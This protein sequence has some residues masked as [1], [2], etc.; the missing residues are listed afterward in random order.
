MPDEK[1]SPAVKPAEST[2]A[3]NGSAAPTAAGAT[4][5][6]VTATTGSV[7]AASA[8]DHEAITRLADDLLPA[9]IAKLGASNLGEIEVRQGGWKARLRKPAVSDEARR[10]ARAAAAAS[11]AP[12]GTS[13]TAGGRSADEARRARE[14]AAAADESAHA[15][16]ISPA[17]G[18]FHPQR[19]L[20]VGMRVRSGD[21]IGTVDVLGVKQ[22]V[23]S[24]VDGIIGSSLV[25]VGEAVE[26][27]QEL[28]RI[29]LP[30]RAATD[31]ADASAA[32]SRGK[33]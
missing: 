33:A 12:R 32:S 9:L 10:A 13:V 17:V 15:T 25:E 1:S 4:S 24:P 2:G 8:R 26:Y 6:A 19:D 11:A 18:I 14:Q 7:S 16:A 27:G 31:G 21:R 3:A 23:T 22:D 28:V 5:T 29:E 30:E 20:T